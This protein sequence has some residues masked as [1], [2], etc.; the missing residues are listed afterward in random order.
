M[1]VASNRSRELPI[2]MTADE[3]T[4]RGTGSPRVDQVGKVFIVVGQR[5]RRCAICEQLFTRRATSEHATVPC[6]P[7]T[8]CNLGGNELQIGDPL[9]TIIVEPLELP[10]EEP[11]AEPRP[12]PTPAPEPEPEPEEVPAT[13]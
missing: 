1:P 5:V 3:K 13:R 12:E 4:Q 11:I 8:R 9:R 6:M 2:D 7:G 10:V